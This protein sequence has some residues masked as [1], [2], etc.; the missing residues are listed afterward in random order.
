MF[1]ERVLKFSEA[2][3]SLYCVSL[4]DRNLTNLFKSFKFFLETFFSWVVLCTQN[5]RFFSNLL[6][7][8]CLICIDLMD[9]SPQATK[10]QKLEVVFLLWSCYAL[11]IYR[12]SILKYIKLYIR[13]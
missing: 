10:N 12:K 8:V 7:Q 2:A 11:K 3:N 9:F 6:K 13:R 1:A 4:H 5:L